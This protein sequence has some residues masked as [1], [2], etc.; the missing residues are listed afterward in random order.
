MMKL[1][2]ASTG[3]IFHR[4]VFGSI[5]TMGFRTAA[6]TGR[7]TVMKFIPVLL[8][9][10][11][12]TFIKLPAMDTKTL[13]HLISIPVIEGTGIYSSV[14]MVRTGETNATA[15]GITNL[16]LVGFNAGLGAYTLFG[17]PE[18]FDTFR[19]VHRITGMVTSAAAVWLAASAWRNSDMKK[20]DR[21]V[22][23]GYSVLT[24]IPV[25]MFS[26]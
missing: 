17:K 18:S 15:A 26:F 9:L 24:V 1:F 5:F 8:V 11:A 13:G 25:I 19:M 20:V 14:Q 12:G 10:A 4:A 21:G 3:K 16:A 7:E 6:A 22:A 23:T 2:L